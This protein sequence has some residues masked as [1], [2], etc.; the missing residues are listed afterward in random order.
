MEFQTK[1]FFKEHDDTEVNGFTIIE[2]A[3]EQ[4][5]I[6]EKWERSKSPT[7]TVYWIPKNRLESR[8]EAGACEKKGQVNDNQYE[9]ICQKTDERALASA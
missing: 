1:D 6:A 3:E 9:A 8:C 5:R 4:V 7:W 2:V